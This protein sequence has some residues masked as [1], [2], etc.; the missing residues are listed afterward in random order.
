MARRT[1]AS[2]HSNF[3][4]RKATFGYFSAAISSSICKALR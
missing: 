1:V 2:E 3:S 4:I